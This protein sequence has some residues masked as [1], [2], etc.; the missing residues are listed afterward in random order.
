MLLFFLLSLL[1]LIIIFICIP[2]R[3][4]LPTAPTTNPSTKTI[5]I[6]QFPLLLLL[7]LPPSPPS[8]SSSYTLWHCNSHRPHCFSLLH[9]A[10]GILW[11]TRPVL[12][13]LS[14][15]VQPENVHHRTADRTEPSTNESH[16]D[17]HSTVKTNSYTRNHLPRRQ[18]DEPC[19]ELKLQAER[20]EDEVGMD[21]GMDQTLKTPQSFSPSLSLAPAAVPRV[22]YE[23]A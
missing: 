20:S 17:D 6:L 5:R 8:S 13:R 2:L 15:I 7:L 9:T 21:V 12:R 19:P 14:V 3:Y 18:Q 4:P 16:G 1:P 23:R 10:L 11:D 22:A